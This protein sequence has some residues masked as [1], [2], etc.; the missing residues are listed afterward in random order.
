MPLCPP[1]AWKCGK[2]KRCFRH[3]RPSGAARMQ[4]LRRKRGVCAVQASRLPAPVRYFAHAR[5]TTDMS[6]IPAHSLW[7]A[8]YAMLICR[9]VT[10]AQRHSARQAIAECAWRACGVAA[11]GA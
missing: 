7:R 10:L 9:C 6:P 11:A 5:V 3:H 2:D 1:G 8:L 4:R